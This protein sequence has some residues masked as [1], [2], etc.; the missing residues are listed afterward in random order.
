MVAPIL[1][2]TAAAIKL[3][4]KGP[5]FFRQERIGVRRKKFH[6]VKFRTMV[7]DAETRLKELELYN[8][9]KGAAFKMKE[10]PRVTKVGRIL[11][12][13]SLDELP[14]FINIL[15]GDMS[16][17]GRRAIRRYMAEA[18]LQC[19]ARSYLSLASQ[20]TSSNRL[21]ALDGARPAVH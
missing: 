20:W 17:V 21:R 4:S 12:K 11:R 2:A 16:L 15:R 9:V 18:P 6:L 14:Q 3:D 10:D 7:T 1:A 8:E 5:V 19:E 13:F